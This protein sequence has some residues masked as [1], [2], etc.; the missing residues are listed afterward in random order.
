MVSKT[1]PSDAPFVKK[2]MLVVDDHPMMRLGQ[3]EAINREPD[4]MV[5][6]QAGTAR[7][8]MESIAHLKPDLVVTDMTLPD[9]NGLELLKDIQALHPGL[10]TLVVSMHEETFYAPRVLRAGGRGYVMKSEGPE[11]VIAAIRTILKG[12]IALSPSMSGQL[13]ET[14]SA[15]AGKAGGTPESRLTDREL[16]VLRFAGEG[17]ATEE[18]AHKLHLSTKTVDVH[19]GKIKEKLGLKT[20]PEFLRY[21][22]RWVQAQDKPAPFPTMPIVSSKQTSR[23]C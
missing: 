17:W 12:Q 16:E 6:G 8:A 22:I 3:V 1:K 19:R 2:K 23:R 10:P 20:T 11:K 4:F 21:A 7:E 14:F 15:P 18:I 5:C 9:K 13:L